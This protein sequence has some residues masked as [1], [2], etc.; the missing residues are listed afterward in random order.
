M[1]RRIGVAKR[2][3][4]GALLAVETARVWIFMLPIALHVVGERL[5][6]WS[7]RQR[8]VFFAVALVTIVVLGQNMTFFSLSPE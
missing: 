3:P 8:A 1:S 5:S 4:A 6:R 7:P 2:K